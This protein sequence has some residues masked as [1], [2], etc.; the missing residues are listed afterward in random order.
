MLRMV[1]TLLLIPASTAA[2]ALDLTLLSGRQDGGHLDH[3]DTTSTLH[4][5]GSSATALILSQPV[6]ADKELEL[7]LSR[8]QTRLTDGA[9]T[10]PAAELI[11]VDIHY[12]HLG[13]TVLSEQYYGARGFLSG[14][15]GLSHFDP[16]LSGASAENRASI[17]LG[18]GARWMATQRLGL[19]LETRFFG[20]LFDS[21]T[22]IFCSG[23]CQFAV[24]G[25]L[26]SQYSLFAGVVVRLD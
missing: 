4:F 22:A 14:G 17:S 23:G 15:L 9:P 20:T 8:Q 16:S 1:F 13:G 3:I 10:L 19:R 11:D 5:E 25:N 18:L 12:L 6:T 7:L 21:N 26:L 24:S 2:M